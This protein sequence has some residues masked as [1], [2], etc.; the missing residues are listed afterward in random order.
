V[1][2]FRTHDLRRKAR[3]PKEE[4]DRKAEEE[5]TPAKEVEA[6]PPPEPRPE[7]VEAKEQPARSYQ[8]SRKPPVRAKRKPTDMKKPISREAPKGRPQAGA[9]RSR[10]GKVEDSRQRA[11]PKREPEH[12]HAP[13][14]MRRPGPVIGITCSFK[15]RP[16]DL[17]HTQRYFFLNQPYVSAIHE[18]GGIPVIVP[19]G[20]ESRYPSKIVGVIDGL[21]LPGGGDIDP[22]LFGDNP[23]EK[24]GHVDPRRD[25]SEIDLFTLAFN[26][27]MPIL[28]ICRGLHLINVALDG[29]LYQDIASQV[30]LSMNHNP[31]FPKSEPCHKIEIENGTRLQKLLGES[32]IWVNSSH[33][34]A[35]KLHGKGLIVDAKSPDGV[36]EGLEHPSKKFVLGVQWHPE[37]YWRNDRLMAK[38]FKEF[39]EACK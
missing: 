10:S 26:Q 5:K 9:D 38:L 12:S 25:H 32:S 19:V 36:T 24:L 18:A 27:N 3:Q 29:T 15:H 35:V 28:G 7:A 31:D 2:I 14:Q 20:L 39:V 23:S 21:L 1:P 13:M 11:E 22:N 34:Q 16:I 6:P 17:D 33:H 30:R 4:T 37:L 8:P